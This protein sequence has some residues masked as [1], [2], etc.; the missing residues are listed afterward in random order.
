MDLEANELVSAGTLRRESGYMSVQATI[1][2]GSVAL[3][4]LG[5]LGVAASL[6]PQPGELPVSSAENVLPLSAAAALNFDLVDQEGR[7]VPTTFVNLIEPAGG[8]PVFV[9]A[10]MRHAAARELATIHEGPRQHGAG[11]EPTIERGV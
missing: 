1:R 6:E 5:F 4:R 11:A 9:L 8:D 3:E 10:R 2:A 7:L